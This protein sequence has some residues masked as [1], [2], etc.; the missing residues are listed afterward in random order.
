MNYLFINGVPLN[1]WPNPRQSHLRD[2]TEVEDVD[3][4]EVETKNNKDYEE[5]E[6]DN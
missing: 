1:V 4:Q 3:Y 2:L 5:A 6:R